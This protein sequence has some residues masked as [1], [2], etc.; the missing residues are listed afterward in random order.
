ML[1]GSPALLVACLV[2]APATLRADTLLRVRIATEVESVTLGGR[3][4][5]ADRRP[6]QGV[7]FT[8]VAE[9][10]AVLLGELKSSLP[11]GVEAL[12][13]VWV[14]GRRY[15]GALSLVPRG[16]DRLDVLN[17]VDLEA[18]VERSVAGEVAATDDARLDLEE[19]DDEPDTSNAASGQRT[20]AAIKLSWLGAGL[21][22]GLALGLVTARFTSTPRPASRFISSSS[23]S[24][25]ITTPLPMRPILFR[26][27]SPEGIR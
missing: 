9:G 17:L 26:C 13:G 8:A 21:V 25:S 10:G 7:D 23:A 6:L 24:G 2:V 18:Y 15:P 27:R 19:T 12:G 5:V 14:N 16:G 11:V 1:R 20:S 3:G 4:L 22:A